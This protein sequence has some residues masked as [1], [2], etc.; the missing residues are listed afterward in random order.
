MNGGR[1]RRRPRGRRS[2]LAASLLG[3][4]LLALLGLVGAAGSASAHST[5]ERFRPAERGMVATGRASLTLWFGEAIN[6]AS[7]SFS[8]RG[9]DLSAPP[10][11][12]TATLEQDRS[13]V[14]LSTPPLDRGTY[15][16][17]WSVVAVDGHPTRGTILFGA[18]FRPDGVP[19]LRLRGSA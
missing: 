18:G 7:S 8:V 19:R 16:I 4:V 1:H 12:T 15:T 10:I 14:H 2:A 13:V 3:A 11:P 17:T 6:G 9:S 5:L